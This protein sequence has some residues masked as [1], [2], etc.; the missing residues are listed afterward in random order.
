MSLPLLRPFETVSTENAIE[1]LVVRFILNVPPEDLS[2]VERVLFHFEEASWFYTDF[3]KLMNSYLPNLS[4]RSFSKMVKEICPLIWKWDITPENALVKFS[5]YKRTIPVRGAAIFNDSLSKILLLRGINSKHWSFPR[6]KIGKDEDDVACCIREVKEETGFDLTG[7][8]DAD[9]YVER[10]MNGKN[11]KIFLVK[12]VPED[13]EFKPEHKNEIQAIEWKDFKKLSRAITKNE[14]SA[15]VFLVNSMIRPLSLYVKNEKR[16]KDE[17]K[18]KL[19]AEE[20]LKSILGLNKKENKI[21]LDAGRELMEMLQK[22]AE[23][24]Q[25]NDGNKTNSPEDPVVDVNQARNMFPLMSVQSLSQLST[26]NN[27]NNEFSNGTKTSKKPTETERSS[28]V[29][30]P[31]SSDQSTDLKT[32]SKEL[33][34]FLHK[35]STGKEKGTEISADNSVSSFPSAHFTEFTDDENYEEFESSSDESEYESSHEQI[36][37]SDTEWDTNKDD[38]LKTVHESN[39]KETPAPKPSK[40]ESKPLPTNNSK[41]TILK[42]PDSQPKSSNAESQSVK[43]KIRLLKRGDKLASAQQS[44]SNEPVKT[45]VETPEESTKPESNTKQNEVNSSFNKNASDD[46]LSILKKP[47]KP[48]ITSAVSPSPLFTNVFESSQT[49]STNHS[50]ASPISPTAN[51]PISDFSRQLSGSSTQTESSSKNGS[52]DLLKLL[53]RPPQKNSDQSPSTELSPASKPSNEL[54]NILKTPKIRSNPP[55]QNDLAAQNVQY[56]IGAPDPQGQPQQHY[57][58][59][60]MMV[61]PYYPSQNVPFAPQGLPPQPQYQYQQ[62]MNGYSMPPQPMNMG[63]PVVNQ[64]FNQ[65]NELLNML[66]KPNVPVQ[67]APATASSE[68]LS[69][70]KR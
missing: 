9:Q 26:S 13:F 16:A 41:P 45:L 53:N 29:Q 43:P 32:S 12:G 6:G 2:T 30:S 37:H 51:H 52:Q 49:N 48:E 57:P 56:N 4:I 39:F 50:V 11:F 21:V 67:E 3:V 65:Q 8:I 24:A 59:Q 69:I 55:P 22:S 5:M 58:M 33:L 63:Q 46:L 62:V 20:H 38:E 54:L 64:N 25:H 61:P 18:L 31:N 14:G 1:D 42:R 40:T 47:S 10:N 34:A 27:T 44:P 15:K 17:T 35:S 7:Y 60:Q 36:N 68:L 28:R 19:Y 66:H 70:L 23:N